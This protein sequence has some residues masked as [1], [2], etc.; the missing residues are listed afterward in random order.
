MESLLDPK[1]HC[2]VILQLNN[3]T[4]CLMTIFSKMYF[5]LNLC[6]SFLNFLFFKEEEL[7]YSFFVNEQEMLKGLEEVLDKQNI[8]DE[9]VLKIEY[10]PQA[11]FRVRQIT[12]CVSSMEG[13]FTSLILNDHSFFYLST[14]AFY[15]YLRS[16]R[17][18]FVSSVQS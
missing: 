2:L 10:Q 1:W 8:N 9:E 16:L 13:M 3:C 4:F 12:R 15:S 11:V 14:F 5:L 6:L 17:S 18:C 7:P